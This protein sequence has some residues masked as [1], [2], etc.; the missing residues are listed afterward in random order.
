M[1]TE[2]LFIVT[3]LETE[4]V[5]RIRVAAGD[6]ITVIHEPDLHPPTRFVADHGGVPGFTRTAD[7]AA[8]RRKASGRHEPWPDV[9]RPRER[10]GDTGR[11]VEQR[12][13]EG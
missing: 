12:E 9:C 1:S 4:H 5:E 8:R 2:T 11:E 7:Q 3:P 10:T 6:A 13:R